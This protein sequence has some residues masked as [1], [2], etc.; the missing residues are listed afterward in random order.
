MPAQLDR[1]PYCRH[2]GLASILRALGLVSCDVNKVVAEMLYRRR[3][4]TMEAEN[5]WPHMPDPDDTESNI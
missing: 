5:A 1:L 4:A 2:L 3:V